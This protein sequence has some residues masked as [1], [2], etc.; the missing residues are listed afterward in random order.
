MGK[1]VREGGDPLLDALLRSRLDQPCPM[2]SS[3]SPARLER[4]REASTGERNKLSKGCSSYTT[5]RG[6]THSGTSG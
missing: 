6:T 2:Y 5:R 1:Q 3:P 4:S